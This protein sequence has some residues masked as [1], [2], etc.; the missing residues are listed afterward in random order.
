MALAEGT[1]GSPGMVMMSPQIMTT[2]S[3]ARGEAH[4]ADVDRVPGRR[5]AQLRIG[6]EG[7]LGLGDAHRVVA[8]ARLLQLL[9]LRA[10]VASKR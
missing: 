10:H 2:N 5:A 1:L 4:L 6:G 8:V 7:I 9:D 3:R